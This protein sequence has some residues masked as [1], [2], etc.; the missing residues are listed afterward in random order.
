MRSRGRAVWAMLLLVVALWTAADAEDKSPGSLERL[1]RR[2]RE[3]QQELDRQRE[4]LEE[5]GQQLEDQ[6]RALEELRASAAKERAAKGARAEEIGEARELPRLPGIWKPRGDTQL[7]LADRLAVGLGVQYRLMHNASNLPGPGGTTV[8]RTEAYDFF[9]QRLRLNVSISPK[10]IPAGGFAQAEFRGGFGGSSPNASDPRGEEPTRNPFNRLQARGIRYGFLYFTPLR[11]QTILGGVLPLSDEFGDTLFSADWDFNVGGVALFGRS[12]PLDYR[13]AYLRLIE[14]VGGTEARSIGRDG[15]FFVVDVMTALTEDLQG[16]VHA[17]YLTVAKGLPLGDTEEWW[18]GATLRGKGAP[19][20]WNAFALLNVG[21]LGIG[22]LDADGKVVS[23]FDRN[24]SHAG[25]AF[26]VEAAR[27]LAALRLALQSLYSSGDSR[28]AEVKS[29]FATPQ[30]L[31]GTEGYWA[32]THI[33]TANGPSDV[34]DLAV[35]LGNGGAGLVTVQGLASMPL[36]ERVTG[37]LSAGW[38]QA[39]RSRNGSRDM[40]TEVGAMTTIALAEGL[41]LDV[42]I[43]GAFLGEFFGP[44]TDDLFEVFTRFQFQY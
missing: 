38:F 27:S 13:L 40:G 18:A 33:F 43:A 31:F 37:Q 44:E 24:D 15:D 32:Y 4:L 26:K 17:Y 25:Y 6:R 23:G 10:G 14:G 5:Q 19:L 36:H 3:Q 28:D 41:N 22:E 8:A 1:E 9:R 21:Q 39:S 2:L 30:G 42:G 20:D 29:R 34:N 7:R 11:E 12:A 16:G 35:E